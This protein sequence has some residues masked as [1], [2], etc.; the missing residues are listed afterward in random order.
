MDKLVVGC[1]YIGSR[2]AKLWIAQGHRVL[3]TT[4]QA[5]HA[6]QLRQLG[7]EPILCDVTDLASLKNLPR[8]ATV[9][10]GIGLDRS[11]GQSMRQVYVD[12][13]GNVLDVLPR[14]GRF[15]YISST[16]VYGQVAGEEVTEDDPAEPLEESG[17]ICREAERLLHARLPEAIILRFAGIYGPGRLLRRAAIANGEPIAAD[18]DR[19][20]N[21][22]H[23]DDGAAAVLAAEDRARPGGIYNISDGQPVRRRE[24][25]EELARRLGAPEPRFR[26]PPP[27]TPHERGQR[28]INNRRM[29]EELQVPL[30]YPDYRAGLTAS[31][32][33]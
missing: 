14:P 26:P 16:S 2:V 32:L 5:G 17:K 30:K 29:R 19:W 13:L 4:R 31:L 3:A 28:R 24:F 27:G 12:G 22:I 21:L 11:A 1:G 6:A 7:L 20:L 23:G 18:P 15:I 33:A 8:V 10:Y 25:F 9:C